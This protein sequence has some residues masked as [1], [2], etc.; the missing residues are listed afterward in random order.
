MLADL[1]Q[2][3]RF[4]ARMLMKKPGFTLIAVLTL[5]LGIGANTAIFSF[6]NTLLLKPLPFPEPARLAAVESINFQQKEGGFGGVSPADFW[7]WK[8]Q[9]QAFEQIAAYSG[10][11]LIL[12]DQEQPESVSA[13]RVSANFFQTFGVAPMLGRAFAPE[14]GFS[15]GP[16]AMVISHRLWQRRFGGNPSIVGQPIKTSSGSVIIAGVMPPDFKFPVNAEAWTPLARD[17]GEM[18]YRSSRYFLAVGRVKS[19]MSMSA[20]EAELKTVAGRLAESHPKDNLNWT[21]K[22]TPLAEY[23]VRDLK[24]SLLVLMG[25]VGLVLLIACANV[26]NLL[27]TAA[28]SRRREL[29]IRLAL[30]ASRWRVMRQ[31][32]AESVLLALAGGAGGLLFAVGGINVFIKLLPTN[33]AAYRP[34][35]DVELDGVALMFTFLVSVLTGVIFG[36]LPG[37]QAS[38]PEVNHF[39]KEGGRGLVGAVQQRTRSV[40]VVSEIALA[41]V[42]LIG[43]GLLMNS[44]IRM[45]RVDVGYDARGLMKI[46]LGLPAQNKPLF[47]RQ[48]RDEVSRV[49]GVESST[50]MSF[51]TFGGLNFPFNL[52][53]RPFSNGDARGRY[54]AVSADYFRTLKTPLR[55]GREFND[56]DTAQSP[57]VAIINETLA[58]SYFAGENPIGKQIV[59]AYLNQRLVREIVGVAAD[60]K[61]DEPNSPTKPEILVPFEQVPWLGATLVVRTTNPNPLSLER[62]VK[63]AILSVN[64]SQTISRV[65]SIE[66]A[67]S[68]Q[69]AEPRLYML[70]LGIFA[71]V[72]MLL[73]VVGIYGVMS[74]AVTERSHEIGIRMA[75]GAQTN[76]VLKMIVGQGL[77]LAVIGAAIGLVAAFA[78]MRLLT[79]L[80]F[81]ISATDPATFAVVAIGLI[82]VALLACY[83]P[84]RR[85]TKVNP[86]TALRW[87]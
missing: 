7:D 38:R 47:L 69:V 87:E 80:L 2:D 45:R 39:L 8:E 18:S 14:E 24:R 27:L 65:V 73:A 26:A 1:W 32:L 10:N 68:D 9:S 6:V 19:G 4:G 75:L 20:A 74:Y 79:S 86:L 56:R 58:N 70:L 82:G 11:G 31:L 44:F 3:L 59:I 37:W 5:S 53:D 15:N 55:A 23:Q 12:T 63:R 84:A 33:N 61:Q 21:V 81:G 77:M 64:K 57:G 25:A 36:L 60:V 43:A 66:Q 76:D 46:P 17:S 13:P 35:G 72:A 29:A 52:V 78:L 50:V 16:R 62:E 71:A 67:L 54:S 40:L 85:A 48:V 34:A 42:M 83:I 30:G 51:W 22:L 49:P 41:L 28:A